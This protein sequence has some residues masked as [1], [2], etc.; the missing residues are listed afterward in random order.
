M[1][2]GPSPNEEIQKIKRLKKTICLRK[3]VLEKLSGMEQELVSLVQKRETLFDELENANGDIIF[4]RNNLCSSFQNF[5]NIEKKIEMKDDEEIV[6]G[7]IEGEV[8]IQK[9]EIEKRNDYER[10]LSDLIKKF[11][12]ITYELVNIN[13]R[14]LHLEQIINNGFKN[15]EPYEQYHIRPYK[16]N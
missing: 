12:M 5:K 16:V 9:I 3:S 4:L 14:I 7:G 8:F 10:D 1:V 11:E 13:R 2:V 6:S 15:M